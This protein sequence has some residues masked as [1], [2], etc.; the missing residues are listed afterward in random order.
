MFIR[1]CSNAQDLNM[2]RVGY[3]LLIDCLVLYRQF[4]FAITALHCYMD[5]VEDAQEMH[6]MPNIWYEIG[7]N[8]RQ[9]GKPTDCLYCLE[10]MMVYSWFNKDT[11]AEVKAYE[12]LGTSYF[13]DGNLKMA[14]HYHD[15]AQSQTV[16]YS[17]TSTRRIAI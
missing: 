7:M 9:Q 17:E 13:N 6:L 2:M 4:N 12:N 1:A 16:E 8:Y 3:R 14:N 15:K 11:G 10:Q 5:L